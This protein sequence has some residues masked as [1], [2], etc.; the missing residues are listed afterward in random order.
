[1]LEYS[2][3]I[4]DSIHLILNLG[5]EIFM[6]V[7]LVA[8]LLILLIFL[9]AGGFNFDEKEVEWLK[10]MVKYFLIVFCVVVTL[11]IFIPSGEIL[12]I[13]LSE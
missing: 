4:I 8:F 11:H 10:R 5:I 12:K 2:C 9:C 7:F 6:A 13:M 1:M 3:W